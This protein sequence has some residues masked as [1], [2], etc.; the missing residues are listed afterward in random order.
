MLKKTVV[1]GLLLVLL[2][3]MVYA[4]DVAVAP[5]QQQVIQPSQDQV[6]S[7]PLQSRVQPTLWIDFEMPSL[8]T[9]GTPFW[10]DIYVTPSGNA[11]GQ[12]PL[13]F[14]VS[15]PSIATFTGQ[16]KLNNQSYIFAPVAVSSSSLAI[17][18]QTPGTGLN[19]L[20]Y[21]VTSYEKVR[22]ARAQMV[23]AQPGTF[24]FNLGPSSFSVYAGNSQATYLYYGLVANSPRRYSS[25]AC[26]PVTACPLNTCGSMSDGCG[27]S[28]NCASV[29][30]E[31]QVC[32]ANNACIPAV[33]K[34]LPANAPQ[35]DKTVLEQVSNSL[36]NGQLN[37]LQKLASIVNAVKAWLAAQ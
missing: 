8:I 32:G 19:P 2:S 20:Y 7:Q 24:S 27:G 30:A 1:V 3:S 11:L 37:K 9:I 13:Q 29:C 16:Y 22:L 23:A 28:I 26:V 17:Q 6:I 10:V 25:G 18:L 12:S 31:G 21:N 5:S 36:S 35:H 15:N 34:A 4:A 33:S 14:T